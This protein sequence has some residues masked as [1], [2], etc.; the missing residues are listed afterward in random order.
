MI[1]TCDSQLNVPCHRTPHSDSALATTTYDYGHHG[2][3]KITWDLEGFK[4]Q[5]WNDTEISLMIFFCN[6]SLFPL[7]PRKNSALQIFIRIIHL[8]SN[9]LIRMMI[10]SSLLQNFA[11]A[12]RHLQPTKCNNLTPAPS[13]Y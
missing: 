12:Q 4:L 1:S 6:A 8:F 13:K 10:M 7:T 9:A 5:D 11:R 3:K 2:Q